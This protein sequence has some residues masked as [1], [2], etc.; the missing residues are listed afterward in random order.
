VSLVL[1]VIGL[2]LFG[3]TQR[4]LII[5]HDAA[6]REIVTIGHLRI[7]PHPKRRAPDRVARPRTTPRRVAVAPHARPIARV[8]APA[9]ALVAKPIVVP[10]L[11]VPHVLAP[12]RLA[13]PQRPSVAAR[14]ERPS[15]SVALAPAARAP[16]A[17]AG[18][19]GRAVLSGAQIASIE[20]SLGSAI[21]DDRRGRDP[22]AVPDAAPPTTYHRGL[23]ASGLTTGDRDHHG[24]CDPIKSWRASGF[25]YY[26]VAGNVR[27]SDGTFE[28]QSVPWPV[29][30]PPDADPFDG[31][32]R[33]GEALQGPLPGWHLAPDERISAELR[34]Y[35]RNLGADI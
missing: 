4:R 27:F 23:D 18:G 3:W 14:S 16:V 20:R 33:G 21:A 8:A 19:A 11:A 22:L 13:P 32:S 2:L 26:Y 12:Q 29:R 9:R 31:T 30:F 10:P 25:D 5:A 34:A 35:A 1:H 15:H 28:R 24:L 17:P 7:E 6:P